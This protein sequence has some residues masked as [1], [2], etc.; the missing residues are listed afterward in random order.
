MQAGSDQRSP[1]EV[2]G[3]IRRPNPHPRGSSF[4]WSTTATG[5]RT[6]ADQVIVSENDTTLPHAQLLVRHREVNR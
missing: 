5:V 3:A 1:Q 6:W 4:R 2:T